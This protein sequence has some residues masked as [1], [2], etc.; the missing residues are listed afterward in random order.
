M[1]KLSNSLN[2]HFYAI[3]ARELILWGCTQD[4]ISEGLHGFKQSN[5]ADQCTYKY[6]IYIEGYAWSVSEKYILSCDSP[7]L[8]V[9]PRFYDFF[10]RSLQPL[11]HYWPIKDNDKCKSIKFAVEWGSHHKRKAQAIGKAASDFLQQEVKME[12]VYDYMFHLLSEYAKLLKFKP[13][14]PQGAEELC[15]EAVACGRDGSEWKFMTESLVK[16]PS[17][18]NPCTMPPPFEPRELGN[19]YRRNVNLIRQVENWESKYWE[20]L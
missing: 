7:T 6:K 3:H 12:F 20:N 14:V 1:S 13:A 18:T 5:I 2:L 19:F 10:T 4:W 16:S 11:H 9:K 15:S 8:L 17:V